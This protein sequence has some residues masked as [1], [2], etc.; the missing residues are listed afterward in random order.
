MKINK[1]LTAL[2]AGA[3]IGMSGQ[4]FAIGTA[5]DTSI[6]NQATLTFDVG[7]VQQDVEVDDAVFTV[8]N[9]IDL[10]LAWNDITATT[11]VPKEDNVVISYKLHNAGNNTQSYVLTYSHE[12]TDGTT[13]GAYTT[14]YQTGAATPAS[15][16]ASPG[17]SYTLYQETGVTSGLQTS[18]LDLDTVLGSDQ[19]GDIAPAALVADLS[20]DSKA[21]IIYLV[22]DNVPAASFDTDILGFSLTA[23]THKSG[24]GAA[25][26]NDTASNDLEGVSE[27]V[28]ADPD[29]DGFETAQS[30]LEIVTAKLSLTKEVVVVS[31]PINS[32]T[33]P[34]A[35]PGA[36]LRYTLTTTN[37]GRA[38]ADAV[39]V[40]EDL[41]LDDA[42][43]IN[44]SDLDTSTIANLSVTDSDSATVIG[45]FQS[46]GKLDVVYNTIPA[47]DITT[48]TRTIT[49]EIDL[50]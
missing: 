33:N 28:F 40:S 24:A 38:A 43:N 21:T 6:T 2:I 50:K 32:T 9:K 4:A 29:F 3:S 20:D 12:A 19:T 10:S 37:E 1:T 35:I 49:F 36:T 8:D 41:T 22:V 44:L 14:D 23:T 34:K 26:V 16:P 7:G 47:G 45:T 25:E 39:T 27:A 15:L 31:D 48:Q 13:I 11:A 18:G 42:N 5:A 17:Y 30:A 46:S